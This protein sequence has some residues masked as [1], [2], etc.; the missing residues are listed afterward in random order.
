[1]LYTDGV[2]DAQNSAGEFFDD[3]RLLAAMGEAGGGNAFEQQANILNR[4]RE[5]MGDAD[6]F[7]DITIM[8][9]ARLAETV[10]EE[11]KSGA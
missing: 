7:D 10:E 9:L 2:T 6:Q 3:D 1:V 5:F 8:V 11:N 4:I